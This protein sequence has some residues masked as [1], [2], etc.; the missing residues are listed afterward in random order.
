MS[1]KK[2]A[3]LLLLLLLGFGYVK[4]FYKTWNK[5]RVPASADAVLVLDVKRVT[6]TLIWQFLSTPSK[7]KTGN[8]FSKRLKDTSWRDMFKL[9]DY[10]FAFHAK[11]QSLNNWY[12]V[13]SMDSRKGFEAGLAKFAFRRINDREY[14]NKE[15]GL[16]LYVHDDNEVLLA[17]APAADSLSVRQVAHELFTE[18]KFMAGSEI[19]KAIDA[20]SHLSLYIT[21][22]SALREAGIFSLNFDKESLRI[23][24]DITPAQP[25]LYA[26]E[27]F[28]YAPESLSSA[29]LVQPPRELLER[30]GTETKE[31][32]SKALG[33]NADSFFVAS[34]RSY[35]IDLQSIRE[36]QDTAITYT[37][38]DDFNPV[39]NKVL[40]T[41]REPA[42]SF[43]ANGAHTDSI[44]QYLLRNQKL[45]NGAGGMVFLPM[46]L[47]RSYC[48]QNKPGNLTIES[49]NYQPR[50]ASASVKALLFIRLSVAAIPPDL[51][52]YLPDAVS[53]RCRNIEEFRLTVN[54]T[55][56]RSLHVS[57]MLTKK[58]NALLLF[59]F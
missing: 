15:A 52:R 4:L 32:I 24:G 43:F 16:Y 45:E 3:L 51:L 54:N 29:G 47:V 38:D 13:L 31:R 58:K 50:P 23:K 18:K 5:T 36:R 9:P 26:E 49:F 14:T 19:R 28:L 20:K 21:P 30:M 57:G 22:G 46:P 34:N 41:V 44:Y 25:Y 12:T 53:D 33:L 10:V 35:S 1:R 39:E 17:R 37:Y 56:N 6:N 11:N 27:N 59:D 40:N 55:D 48:R 7:W 8:L 2:W 42:F